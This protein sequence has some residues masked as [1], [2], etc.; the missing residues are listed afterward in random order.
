MGENNVITKEHIDLLAVRTLEARVFDLSK[1]ILAG[2]PQKALELFHTLII[3]KEDPIEIFNV[4]LMAFVDIYRA[5]I[6]LSG[7]KSE[8]YAANFYD[9]RN[10]EFRLSNGSRF[11]RKISDKD[12]R[13]CFDELA[14]SD[15][16]LKS[17]GQS[18]EMI[19]E[20]LIVKLS[21][22]LAR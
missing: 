7:G 6:S 12:L 10:K 5:K 21:L 19:I 13:E 14:D 18:D 22:I 9:Y 4:I 17:T 3:Q 8:Q 16:R 1:Y 11:G 20:R 15:M 2:N